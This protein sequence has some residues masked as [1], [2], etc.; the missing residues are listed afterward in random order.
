MSEELKPC[1]FCGSPAYYDWGGD[2]GTSKQL[3]CP[4]DNCAGH[5]VFNIWHT[6]IGTKHEQQAIKAWN[7]RVDEDA[8]KV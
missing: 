6:D 3:G 7:T 2:A 1:P 8:T 5:M 4:D